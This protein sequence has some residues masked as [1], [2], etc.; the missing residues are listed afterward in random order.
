M[1]TLRAPNQAKTTKLTGRLL[2]CLRQWEPAADGP[3]IEVATLVRAFPTIP[4]TIWHG[5]LADTTADGQ[6]PILRRGIEGR[7][8]QVW[9]IGV[10]ARGLVEWIAHQ[11]PHYPRESIQQLVDGLVA[12]EDRRRAENRAANAKGVREAAAAKRAKRA[13]EAKPERKPA[14][15][16]RV[17][18]DALWKVWG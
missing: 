12:M 9:R 4:S 14:K 13:A 7:K 3:L 17:S 2:R 15:A 8:F 10:L 16:P 1:T 5:A 18:S 6:R 11:N